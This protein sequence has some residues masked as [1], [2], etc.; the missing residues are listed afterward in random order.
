MEKE[1]NTKVIASQI[2]LT[3]DDEYT[4]GKL[5]AL[6][7][8]D[9]LGNP[10]KVEVREQWHPVEPTTILSKAIEQVER[11]G[12][13][14]VMVALVDLNKGDKPKEKRLYTFTDVESKKLRK[15]IYKEMEKN[16][17]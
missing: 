10:M 1:K 4:A 8:K 14:V 3:C 7:M 5:R 9:P 17:E 13:Y 12:N 11:M 15:V 2:T 16:C 6:G